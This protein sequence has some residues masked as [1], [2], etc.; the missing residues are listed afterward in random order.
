M[1]SISSRSLTNR[2]RLYT[3][4]DKQSQKKVVLNYRDSKEE[5]QGV[6]VR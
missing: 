5:G 2:A 6:T 1:N 4:E 3:L